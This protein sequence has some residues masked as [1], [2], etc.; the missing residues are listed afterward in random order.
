M[1]VGGLVAMMQPSATSGPRQ[2]RLIGRIVATLDD[3]GD[4]GAAHLRPN[5]G[6]AFWTTS[7]LAAAIEAEAARFEQRTGIDCEL[8]LSGSSRA[9]T[10]DGAPLRPSI[11]SCRESLTNVSR[12]ANASRVEL[13]LR[14]RPEDCCSRFAMMGEASPPADRR[15]LFSRLLGIRERAGVAGGTVRIEGVAGRGTIVSVRIP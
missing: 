11:A 7:G 3:T 12:H 4:R 6:R 2:N 1:D 15:S 5:S 13:R 10:I 8:S 9:G 14:Q